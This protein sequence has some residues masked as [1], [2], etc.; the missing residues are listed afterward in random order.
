LEKFDVTFLRFSL[1]TALGSALMTASAHAENAVSPGHNGNKL[2]SVFLDAGPIAKMLTLALAIATLA[3]LALAVVNA[4][5][6]RAPRIGDRFASGLKPGGLA[7]GLAG[8]AFLAMNIVVRMVYGGAVPPFI[9]MAPGFAEMLM[10]LA[11]GLLASAAGA[12]A[13]AY[14]PTAP[15]RP[16]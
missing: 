2:G 13:S 4:L 15:R 7:L 10:V 8:V 6:P 16:A 1:C 14:T 9:V 5:R 11:A 3:A 12:F